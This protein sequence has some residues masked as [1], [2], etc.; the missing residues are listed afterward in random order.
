MQRQFCDNVGSASDQGEDGGN[1][2]RNSRKKPTFSQ[3]PVSLCRRGET[4]GLVVHWV[5]WLDGT[6][7]FV[8]RYTRIGTRRE[9]SS[10]FFTLIPWFF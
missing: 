4:G 9:I 1:L 2:S 6:L 7:L 5:R 10:L 3:S 8:C